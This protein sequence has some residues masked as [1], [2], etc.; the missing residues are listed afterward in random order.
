MSLLIYY[1]RDST[2][3]WSLGSC[4]LLDIRKK[5]SERQSIKEAHF[6]FKQGPPEKHR[7]RKISE[8]IKIRDMRIAH[9]RY[10]K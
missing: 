2:G 1:E 6:R 8:A 4:C 7:E 5:E 10:K 9:K 3:K